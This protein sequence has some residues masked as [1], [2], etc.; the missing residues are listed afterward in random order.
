MSS[1]EYQHPEISSYTTSETVDQGS[2]FQEFMIHHAD[3]LGQLAAN[4]SDITM[5]QQHIITSDIVDELSKQGVTE[6]ISKT[7]DLGLIYSR[8]KHSPRFIES[9]LRELIL[10]TVFRK[11][12]VMPD[13]K[14]MVLTESGRSRHEWNKR[15]A[16]FAFSYRDQIEPLEAMLTSIEARIVPAF[17]AYL[18]DDPDNVNAILNYAASDRNEKDT[19]IF[20]AFLGRIEAHER[21]GRNDNVSLE[22][23]QKFHTEQE[24]GNPSSASNA[25]F[26]EGKMT[27]EFQE[28]FPLVSYIDFARKRE[29]KKYPDVAHTPLGSMTPEEIVGE[30][31][32]DF[33]DWPEPLRQEHSIFVKRQITRQFDALR[34]MLT[35][36]RL[37]SPAEP[38]L[39]DTHRENSVT[40]SGKKRLKHQERKEHT[41]AVESTTEVEK[42]SYAFAVY[43]AGGK[44]SSIDD[45]TVKEMPRI[46]TKRSGRYGRVPAIQKAIQ[47]GIEGLL[48]DPRQTGVEKTLRSFKYTDGSR[49]P[50]YS[51]GFK[52]NPGVVVSHEVPKSLRMIFFLD[53]R[54]KDHERLVLLGVGDH[55][56]YESYLEQF[57][58]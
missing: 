53:D 25:A 19:Q 42:K 38:Y 22:A 9:E 6:V 13:A 28:G 54:D 17:Y 58:L 27:D 8:E 21:D 56:W 46:I 4:V 31:L 24:S 48:K 7:E 26:I 50:I 35:S 11:E 30:E 15:V 51:Y 39:S 49:T 20:E 23:M 41:V 52:R 36:H 16:Q 29:I 10:M 3:D 14:S 1:K 33:F 5:L 12:G 57:T 55:E 44:A 34:T 45:V 18:Q 37:K 2:S 40:D 43:K 32:P 47:E